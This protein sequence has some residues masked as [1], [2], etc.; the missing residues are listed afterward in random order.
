VWHEHCRI[1]GCNGPKLAGQQLS[2]EAATR[3][4]SD[5]VLDAVGRRSPGTVMSLNTI[6]EELDAA[7]VPAS[8][9]AGLMRRACEEQ[10]LEPYM[11]TVTVDEHEVSIHLGIPS[12]GK[13]AKGA[14]V[15]LYRR[16][17]SKWAPRFGSEVW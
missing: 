11:H 1:R 7:E 16:T 12:D 6:R 17:A 15:K 3:L 9:R 14:H 10:L 8:V 5:V 13:S 4:D 2:L